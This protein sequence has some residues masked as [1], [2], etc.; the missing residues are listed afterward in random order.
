MKPFLIALIVVF[1]I[2]LILLYYYMYNIY[3]VVYKTSPKELY[4]DFQSQLTIEA[5]PMNAL[6]SKALFRSAPAEF[7]IIEG[8]DLVEIVKKDEISGILIL[9][10]KGTAGQ[11]VIRI[12]S[13]YAMLPSEVKVMVYPNTA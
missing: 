2:A 5:V 3:E 11:V 9:K 6:G 1:L 13:K 10:A 12:T 7:N 8:A 4:A